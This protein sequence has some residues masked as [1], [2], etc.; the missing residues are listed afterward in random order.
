MAPSSVSVTIEDS[1]AETVSGETEVKNYS[2][3]E[4]AIESGEGVRPKA[5]NSSGQNSRRQ[6]S[7][8]WNSLTRGM[9]L[10][11]SFSL[12]NRESATNRRRNFSSTSSSA[13]S[14]IHKSESLGSGLVKLQ[15]PTLQQD[16]NATSKYL[17]SSY[18]STSDL[19]DVHKVETERHLEENEVIVETERIRSVLKSSSS[20]DCFLEDGDLSSRIGSR[21]SDL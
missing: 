13:E 11:S 6:G 16:V 5:S 19:A 8:L 12:P 1:P 4:K 17:N 2:T 21:E 14:C 7:S 3:E 20:S 18:E 10:T 9:S 15:V